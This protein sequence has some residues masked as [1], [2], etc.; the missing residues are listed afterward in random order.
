MGEFWREYGVPV[1]M[2]GLMHVLMLALLLVGF[3]LPRQS[4]MAVVGDVE[5]MEAVIIDESVLLEH[6]NRVAEAEAQRQQAARREIEEAE[7]RQAEAQAQRE[8]EEAAREAARRAEADAQREQ[9]L[10]RERE[11]AER[12][13]QQEQAETRAR[14]E[15]ERR[16][17]EEEQ[18]RQR[19][20]AERREREEAQR[21]EREAAERRA[22]EEAER[23]AREEAERRARD[24]EARRQAERESEL[25]RM[26]EGEERRRQAEQAGLLDQYRRMIEQRIV[27]NWARPPSA[28]PGLRCE[29]N[30]R[31]APGGTVLDVRIGTCNGDEAV[32]RSI[33]AAVYRASPLPDPPDPSLFER[34]LTIIF[35]PE[36]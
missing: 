9:Q 34:N 12:V 31:Q 23:R 25:R 24:E 17:R 6:T 3:G 32:R 21:R 36:A 2:A 5:L 29:V 20:E 26:M 8:R 15:A 11:Q 28:G 18:A 1:L 30:V 33:E 10:A 16:A 14:E 7:R 13:R 4:P 19:A 22:R 27:R 35:R